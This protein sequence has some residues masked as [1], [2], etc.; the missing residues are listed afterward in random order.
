MLSIGLSDAALLAALVLAFTH[1]CIPL[2]YYCY[3]RSRRLSRPWGIRRDPGYRL[4]VT[5]IVPTY[6]EAGLIES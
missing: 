4:R 1:F 2:A 6:N 3:L 5:I